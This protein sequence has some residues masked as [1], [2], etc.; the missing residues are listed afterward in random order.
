M[1]VVSENGHDI[2]GTTANR[3]TNAEPGM[4]YFD[5]DIGVLLACNEDGDWVD[6]SGQVTSDIGNGAAAGSGVSASE[7]AG[8]VHTTVLTLTASSITMTDAGAAGCHGGTKIYDFPVGNVM[9]LGATTD[10]A[11]TAGSGGITDTASV[12]G[13]VGTVVTATDNATLLSTEANI[14]PS[15]VATLTGGVGACDGQSTASVILD[16][17]DT[18][19]DAYLNFAVPDAG[20]TANDTL[21]VT[22]TV[23]LVWINFG[24]N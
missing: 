8:R 9:I 11:I 18:A 1:T 6:P 12:V 13:A 24:D 3:P 5:T 23:T 22:G 21:S 10:L 17:T 16:G 19:A 14:V 7:Q 20:S 4:T 15:T 2:S